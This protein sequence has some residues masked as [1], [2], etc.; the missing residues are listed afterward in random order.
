STYNVAGESYA[1]PDVVRESLA[2]RFGKQGTPEAEPVAPEAQPPDPRQ[3]KLLAGGLPLAGAGPEERQNWRDLGEYPW[4]AETIDPMREQYRDMPWAPEERIK[5]DDLGKR[6]YWAP[7]N[8]RDASMKLG[9]P[10]EEQPTPTPE[11]QTDPE[12]GRPM[13]NV[14]YKART[15]E[16]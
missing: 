16:E 12:T 10:S 1:D 9:G 3:L 6:L 2:Y 4:G 11:W 14:Q 8:Y 7:R 5:P 13:L 15:R